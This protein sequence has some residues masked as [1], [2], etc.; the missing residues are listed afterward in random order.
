MVI[1][2]SAYFSSFW[3]KYVL[4][5]EVKPSMSLYVPPSLTFID[6]LFCPESAILVL[7]IVQIFFSLL[8]LY[9]Q[10]NLDYK[11][12]YVDNRG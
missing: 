2:T 8:Y 12:M 7:Y 10:S 9:H 3:Y 4:E 6:S 11:Y 1:L 5:W